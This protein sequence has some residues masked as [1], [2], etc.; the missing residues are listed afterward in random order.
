MSVRVDG[1]MKLWGECMGAGWMSE[2][3]NVWMDEWVRV[4]DVSNE[5]DKSKG[6]ILHVLL[7]KM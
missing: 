1:W 2:W 4:G 3:V 6:E 7:F 5:I